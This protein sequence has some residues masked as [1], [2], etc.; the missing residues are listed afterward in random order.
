VVH[1]GQSSRFLRLAFVVAA[2][3][4]AVAAAGAGL[5]PAGAEPAPE[6]IE[7]DAAAAEQTGLALE[8]P[9]RSVGGH[10]VVEPRSRR[11][12]APAV[13]AVA[14]DGTS[15]ALAS[16]GAQVGPLV[17]SR[18]DGAVLQ[19]SLP[20][21][22]GAAY[23][24]GGGWLAVVDLSGALWRV[25]A[26]SGE[27]RRLSDGPY[28]SDLTV[29]PD[30]RVL[31]LTLSAVDAPL[32]SYPT[33]VDATSGSAV[34]VDP[35]DSGSGIVYRAVALQDGRVA[36]AR[37]EVGGGVVVELGAPGRPGALLGRLEGASLLDVS[38]DGTHLAWV[39]SGRA[40]SVTG[41]D[42]APRDLGPG[43]TVRFAPAGLLLMVVD[44]GQAVVFEPGGVVQAIL[45]SSACWLGG[46][47]GCRP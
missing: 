43:R 31:A 6:V 8:L 26:A 20:G 38:A 7:L 46:G 34:P 5:R 39:A 28:A 45:S 2:L 33:W 25:D 11:A 16:A 3:V 29:L 41:D 35:A 42:P 47:R 15:A 9:V 18:P 24:P 13:L 37:R 36:V 17:L 22:R 4:L 30:G 1:I 23:E 14:P 12:D 19:V 40:M 44:G 21:A 32:W 27:A 10:P